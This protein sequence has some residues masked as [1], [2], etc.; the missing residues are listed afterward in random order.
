KILIPPDNSK[1]EIVNYYHVIAKKI[2]PHIVSRYLTVLRCPDGLDSCFFQ[3]HFDE[4]TL[5][6]FKETA[7]SANGEEPNI[8]IKDTQ[9]LIQL[10]QMDS[11]EIHPWGSRI[12]DPEKPDR[13]IF[14]LDPGTHVPWSDVIATGEL[15]KKLLALFELEG[16]VKTSGGKGLHITI[17]VA[18]T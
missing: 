15:F 5:K 1:H 2:L 17:P 18:R 11:L 14:D 6:L 12:D 16:F 10:V 7:A 3:R 4:A 13:L 9:D 8:H